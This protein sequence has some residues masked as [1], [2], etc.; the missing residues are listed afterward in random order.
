[1]ISNFK[2]KYNKSMR[3]NRIKIGKD[4]N[5]NQWKKRKKKGKGRLSV[6]STEVKE[7]IKARQK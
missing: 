1:M 7:T 2:R 6:F 3:N 4:S 5:L